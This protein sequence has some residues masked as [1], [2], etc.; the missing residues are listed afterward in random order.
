MLSLTSRHRTPWHAVAP[1]LKFAML[2]AAT[3]LLFAAPQ[4]WVQIAVLASVVCAYLVGG[5][6]FTL[7]GLRHLWPLV[8]FLVLL[9]LWHVFRSEFRAGA[10][11]G[12]RIVALVALANLITMTTRLDQMISIVTRLLGPFARL[13]LPVGAI[14]LSVAMVIRF[15]PQLAALLGQ[16]REAW[17]ARS[18]RRAGVRLA[19]PLVL[20]ALDDADRVGEAIRARGGIPK[21]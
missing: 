12:A 17:R 10:A 16:L 20:L 4:L 14:G 7:E 9:M 6:R 21:E 2:I 13:G 1:T 8:P 18:Q 19:V 5:Q 11:M 3:V 15:T